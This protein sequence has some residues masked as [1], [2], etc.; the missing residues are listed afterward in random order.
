VAEVVVVVVFITVA[1]VVISAGRAAAA[2]DLD[3]KT[4]LA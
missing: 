1:R 3:I 2:V 4:T